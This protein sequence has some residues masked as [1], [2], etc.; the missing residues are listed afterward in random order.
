MPVD[1]NSDLGEGLGSWSMGDDDALLGIVTSANVACGFHA[2]DAVIMRRVAERAVRNKVAIGA[3]VAYNDLT[4]FG[5]RFI[6][7]DPDMLQAEVMYQIGALAGLAR[8]AGG[9]VTYVKPHGGLYNTIVH[10]EEQAKAVVAAVAA[11]DSSLVLMGLPGS[12]VLRLAEQKGL[13]TVREAFADRAYTP[14]GTL[15]PRKEK[16]SVLHDPEQIAQRCIA[17]AAGEPIQDINGDPLRLQPD[18]IC[19]HGD[20]PGAVGIA[21]GVRAALERAGV[22]LASFVTQKPHSTQDP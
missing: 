1:L 14:E 11:Y 19:V 16:D 15:V 22:E 13:Q 9:A 4:G 3:H 20:T 17:M 2:G 12:V 5:R 10:H 8:L 6:D 7:M 21:R 18:S